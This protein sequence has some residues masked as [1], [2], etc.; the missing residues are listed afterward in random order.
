MRETKKGEVTGWSP[1]LS[2]DYREDLRFGGRTL[3][4]S[5]VNRLR[6]KIGDVHRT[7]AFDDGAV[8]IFLRLLQV[9]LNEGDTLDTRAL[10][11]SKKLKHLAGFTLVGAGDNDDFFAAFNVKFKSHVREPPERAK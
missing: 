8:R 3:L 11:G 6:L 2:K 7:L 9:A 4:R 10:L 1:T 5:V